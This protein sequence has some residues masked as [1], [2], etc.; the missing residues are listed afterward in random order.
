MVVD[1]PARLTRQ[2]WWV[3]A[4]RA[5]QEFK[6]DGVVD[7]AA[8]LTYYGI[9][10]IFPGLLVLVSV[11]G[12]LG[13]PTIEEIRDVVRE[14]APGQVGDFLDQAI[15]QVGAVSAAG[16]V[17]IVGLLVAFWS[18]S[19]YVSAF[20][21][22]TN[23]INELPEGRPAWKKLPVRLA[24]TAVIGLL[25]VMSAV[26]VVF[27]GDLAARVGER[28]GLGSTAVTVW[29]FAKWPVLLILV[30]LMLSI[31]YWATPEH[32]ARRLPLDHVRRPGGGA[33]V[34][35]GVGRLRR[36]RRQLRLVQPHLRRDC[37]RDRLP[38]L[39]LAEQ[40]RHPARR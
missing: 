9:L 3:A 7:L 39:A 32:P 36:L 10:S 37:R 22:A 2:Q 15:V 20:M 31:L 14:L 6:R 28:I 18:A 17:A 23:T 4:K 26:I 27:T 12:L 33:G 11:L 30:S 13:D 21:R 24:V 40:L 35:A 5:V 29:N 1:K 25:L 34:A 16:I 8:A 19:G 38:G